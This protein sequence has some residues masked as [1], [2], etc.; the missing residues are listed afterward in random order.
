[1]LDVG[2][3]DSAQHVASLSGFPGSVYTLRWVDV[4]LLLSPSH[5]PAFSQVHATKHA[6]FKAY[7][8]RRAFVGQPGKSSLHVMPGHSDTPC[9]TFRPVVQSA[10]PVSET[11]SVNRSSDPAANALPAEQKR[12]GVGFSCKCSE[13]G[14]N[15]VVCIDGTSNQFGINV[16]ASD[17]AHAT[18]F[19]LFEMSNPALTHRTPMS[20]SCTAS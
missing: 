20:S 6:A 8:P 15:L 7:E 3:S 11:N 14:R 12:K 2:G 1:M 19:A 16:R 13:G 4:C 9:I 5:F 10:D 18:P 17:I